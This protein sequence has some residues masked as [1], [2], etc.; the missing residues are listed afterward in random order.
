MNKK[1]S[2]RRWDTQ[3]RLG[4]ESF[5]AKI[6]KSEGCWLWTGNRNPK[7]YGYMRFLGKAWLVHRLMFT[8]SV[9]PIPE[10]LFICHT[11]DVPNCV[12]PSHLFV[13]TKGDNNRDRHRKGRTR[14]KRR[15]GTLNL[16]AKLS[17]RD[18]EDIRFF[19]AIGAMT[20][21]ALAKEFGISQA[22]VSKIVLNQSWVA[23]PSQ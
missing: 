19:Y 13:G 6:E 14:G 18:V 3:R 21:V 9:G 7:G 2:A 12:R 4:I 11:C 16:Q 8:L 22:Q 20:Q 23:M 10:G 17:W 5:N 15:P 1:W